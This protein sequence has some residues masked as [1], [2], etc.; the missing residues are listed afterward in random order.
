MLNVADDALMMVDF[1]ARYLAAVDEA[2]PGDEIIFELIVEAAEGE[3]F[4]AAFGS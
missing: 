2:V 4:L 3:G 1:L